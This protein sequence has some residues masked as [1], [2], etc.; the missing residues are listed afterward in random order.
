MPRVNKKY[1]TNDLRHDGYSKK[2]RSGKKCVECGEP[3]GTA[4]TPY[5]CPKCDIERK[6][7]ISASLD[8]FIRAI[9]EKSQCQET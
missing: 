6:S 4:W 8:G 1:E 2:H 3:A 9:E 5:W 7:R